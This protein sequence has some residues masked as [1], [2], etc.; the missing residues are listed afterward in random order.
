MANTFRLKRSAVSGKVPTT[1]DLQLGELAVN[2]FDG[3]LYTLKNNGTAS[4]VE[5]SASSATSANTAGA[6]V[7]RDGS[8][9]FSAGTI[10][11]ALSGNASTATTLQ[12]ARTINGTSFN[13]SANITTLNWGTPRTLTVGSTGKSVDGSGN[14][15]W[16]LTEIGAAATAHKY[17]AFSSGQYFFDSYEQG[18]YFRLFTENATYSTAR[19]RTISSVEYWDFSASAWVAWTAG[20]SGVKN[21][22]DGRQE[23]GMNVTHENRKF[24]FIVNVASGWPTLLLYFLQSTWSAISYPS[25]TVTLESSTTQAGSYTLRDTAVFSSANTGNNWGLHVKTTSALHTGDSFVRV[26]IDITDWTD[27]SGYTTVPLRNFDMLSNYSGSALQPFS[28]NYDKVVAFDATPTAPTAAV[29]TNTTALATTAFVNA[30]IAND[31]PSKTGTNA[32]GTWGISITGSAASATTATN[33]SGGTVSATTGSFSGDVTQ[34]GTGAIRVANGTTAQRPTGANG[35][36][37]YNTTLGAIET[38][39]QGA[40][41]V[42]ANTAL[43]Y[44]LITTAADTTFDYGA[45]V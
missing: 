26:T 17:H 11:A 42:I 1:G 36:I 32:S 13:G 8:G 6:I 18:N 20:E 31:A 34:T 22:L 14:I 3:K 16:S 41:Q 15:A 28:W 37:R 24:R 25:M 35:H 33:Q 45:L 23:T 21:L 12:T 19:Y 2:T 5:L 44:G 10:S 39:V 9:N 27:T 29:G 40:W 38:F 30:E 4:V 43:D 7:S